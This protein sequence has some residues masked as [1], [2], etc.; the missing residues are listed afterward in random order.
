MKAGFLKRILPPLL[1]C[2]CARSPGP[3]AEFCLQQ[4][5]A[6]PEWRIEDAAKW[7]VHATRGG[8]HAIENETAARRWLENEWSTLGPPLP[9]EPL[10]VPLDPDG[11][12]G[13]LNLR[14]YRARGGSLD[15]L[16]EAFVAGARA[17]DA[18]PARFRRAWIA[19]GRALKSRPIGHLSRAEWKRLDR[20]WRAQGCPAIHHS[21]EYAAARAPAYRVLPAEQA[22][23]LL[24]SL[25]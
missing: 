19:L 6:E 18:S 12:I 23:P 7:L 2:T 17:F 21:R 3:D 15:A 16:H 24:D 20:S 11:R 14:P 10:W 25:P 13:R 1:L 22:Q 8:E 4:A 5:R 9:D